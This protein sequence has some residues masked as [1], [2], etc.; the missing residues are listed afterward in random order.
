VASASDRLRA[1]DI[2]EAD[3]ETGTCAMAAKLSTELWDAKMEMW[4]AHGA[5]E[6]FDVFYD[7]AM[8][9]K[10]SANRL[11]VH[12]P[13]DFKLTSHEREKL[14]QLRIERF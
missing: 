3:F 12:I 2:D 11:R 4:E 5:F 8:K 9:F 13:G 7:H 10:T 6:T 1:L 14:G